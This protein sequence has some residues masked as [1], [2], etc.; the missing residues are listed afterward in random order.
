MASPETEQ[1]N[2]LLLSHLNQALGHSGLPKDEIQDLMRQANKSFTCNAE[3]QRKKEVDKLKLAWINSAEQNN[4]EKMKKQLQDNRKKYFLATKGPLFYRN[5]VLQPEFDA[6]IQKFIK[7]QQTNL[8]TIHLENTRTLNAYTATYSSLDGNRQLYNNANDKNKT[9]KK[10]L[11]RKERT[12]N[13]AERRVYYEF[14]EMDKLEYYN[15]IIKI[16]YFV[17]LALYA[18]LSLRYI[19]GE[20]KKPG[21]WI[22]VVVAAA[23]PFVL[24]IATRYI[25]S[26]INF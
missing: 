26:Y 24:P 12:T 16:V 11:D 8:E 19:A 4:E 10:E 23:F 2:K 9:L 18:I 20:Y 5:N 17:V 1:R 14:Q 3:C 25:L 7:T 21:F 6:E 15:K 13:T 22:F